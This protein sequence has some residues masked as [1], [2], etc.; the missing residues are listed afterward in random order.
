MSPLEPSSTEAPE[1]PSSLPPSKCIK[2]KLQI[3]LTEAMFGTPPT[4]K[5]HFD[6][7]KLTHQHSDHFITNKRS[8][9]FRK[10]LA[11]GAMRR[12]RH[13]ISWMGGAWHTSTNDI[14]IGFPSPFI[15]LSSI[16]FSH[17]ISSPYR[18]Q[19]ERE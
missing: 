10:T 16:L 12:A 9:F 14:R 5:M 13:G 15:I 2:S 18:P 19:P 11:I 4:P 7:T 3:S 8:T 6:P 17:L 1:W